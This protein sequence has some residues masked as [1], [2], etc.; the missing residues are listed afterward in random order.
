M[1]QPRAYLY[2]AA[3]H[4]W[5]ARGEAPVDLK[6][7]MDAAWGKRFRRINHFI[8]LA[9]IGVKSCVSR[10]PTAVLPG[11]DV[12]LAS[13]HG[14]V[15]DVAKITEM[16]VK[17]KEAPMPLDFLNVPNNMA[18]FYL[19]QGLGLHSANMAI[20]HRAFPFETALDIALFNIS[21]SGK[22]GACA[23]VG[24][25]EEV[26]YPL[27]QHRQRLGLK[28]NAPLVEESS[29]FFIGN[30][31]EGAIAEFEWV[32]FFH[33]QASMFLFFKRENL[34]SSFLAYGLGV[35]KTQAK[36]LASSLMIGDFYHPPSDVA[37]DSAS[38]AFTM[39]TFLNDRPGQ[40]LMH[41]GRDERGRHAVVKLSA[42][43]NRTAIGG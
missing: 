20:A 31:P 24:S 35:N 30:D 2:S 28:A 41:V 8:E 23:L 18:G 9:L 12:Y 10:S 7:Q 11:C 33:D 29:W 5:P 15:A 39:A 38:C 37:H 6:A 40:G 16:I 42:V 25:V 13:E 27:N 3:S 26:A 32:K 36:R 19:A 1:K 22:I 43:K 4:I 34:E 14:N 21:T 17:Q